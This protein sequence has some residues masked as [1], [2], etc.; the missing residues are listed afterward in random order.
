M[1]RHLCSLSGEGCLL[2][3]VSFDSTKHL[4]DASIK[5]RQLERQK[6]QELEQQREEQKRREKEAEERQ[7]AEE[8]YLLW[9]Q[10]RACFCVPVACHGLTASAGSRNRAFPEEPPVLPAHPAH[11]S[12]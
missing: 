11:V 1:A 9:E 2:S 3:L 10:A 6:L 8:R 5:K 4:S 7:R 12:R